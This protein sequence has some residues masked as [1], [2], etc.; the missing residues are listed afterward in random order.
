MR[1]SSAFALRP[2]FKKKEKPAATDKRSQK[3][4]L[5]EK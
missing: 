1:L 5:D 3:D 2:V 4:T